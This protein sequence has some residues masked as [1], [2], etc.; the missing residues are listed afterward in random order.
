MPADLAQIQGEL[1]AIQEVC[2]EDKHDIQ[3]KKTVSQYLF[4]GIYRAGS[5]LV[6]GGGLLK[7]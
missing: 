7:P 1:T 6:L 5:L 4:W 2:N 3:H